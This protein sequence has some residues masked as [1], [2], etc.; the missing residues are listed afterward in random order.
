M[1]IYGS[2][3]LLKDV[4]DN[5]LCI[6]CGAC[7][8]LCPY[9][10][11]YR[12]KTTMLFDCTLAQGRCYAHC[13]KAEVDLGEL[14]QTIWGKDY[15]GSPMGTFRSMQASRAGGMARKGRFQGG[16]T[17]TALMQFCLQ[18]GVI[19]GAV[20]TDRSGTDLLPCRATSVEEI[21]KCAGSK[22]MAAPT[23]ALLNRSV[24]D[25]FTRLG[26]VGTP[27]QMTAV[28]QMRAN[29]LKKADFV[30]PVNITVGL[31]CNWCL[32][33]RRLAGFLSDR[34]DISKIKRMDIPPPPAKVMIIESDKDKIEIPLEEIKPMI[35]ATCFICPD[36]TSE[37]SDLSVGMFE[38][39]PGW[40]TLV[41][42][43]EKG[44]EVAEAAVRAKF[45][46]METIPEKNR[47]RLARAA[48]DKKE[49]AFRM[50]ARKGLI[51]SRPDA[52]RS[53][54]RIPAETLKN[55]IDAE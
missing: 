9:F 38:G 28:A 17:V 19:N 14:S 31:F 51:N 12:G 45:L 33:P 34:L 27:C 1:Q 48:A 18:E 42:R 39:R 8:N 36:L 21:T 11:N 4:H 7:V 24:E 3:E 46:E 54:L 30:D 55:M 16:G 35:P 23:L 43:S 5:D 10:K 15:D 6:G 29:F 37:W 40:N 13:P 47:D 22:F 25:G 44:A 49:R 2:K 52:G 20:L 53:A 26:V 32:D 41:I 50:L